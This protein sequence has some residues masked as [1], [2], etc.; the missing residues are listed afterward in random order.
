MSGTALAQT[1]LGADIDGEAPG[2]AS[3]ASVSLS[4]DGNRLAIGAVK[5]IWGQCKIF[6]VSVKTLFVFRAYVNNF[7]SDPIY[8]YKWISGLI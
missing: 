7:Y 5:N 4:A 6:G 8:Y 2:D 1:Q 3:G